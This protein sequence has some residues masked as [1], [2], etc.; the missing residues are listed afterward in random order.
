[1]FHLTAP[2]TSFL[3]F[4]SSFFSKMLNYSFKITGKT[5]TYNVC[6]FP[7]YLVNTELFCS[8]EENPFFSS[9][10]YGY[11]KVRGL[12]RHAEIR[13][14]EIEKKGLKIKQERHSEAGMIIIVRLIHP[15]F[16]WSFST[17]FL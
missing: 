17:S 3:F 7:Q 11:G 13:R 9:N 16:I 2:I 5:H 14:N 6:I 12:E 10:K 1:M 4:I 8:L 15:R